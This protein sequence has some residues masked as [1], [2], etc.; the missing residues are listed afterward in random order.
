[1][2]PKEYVPDMDDEFGEG[3]DG[4]LSGAGS[5]LSINIKNKRL[6]SAVARPKTL[7]EKLLDH[8]KATKSEKGWVHA[9]DFGTNEL[10]GIWNHCFEFEP[11]AGSRNVRI[12]RIG[13]VLESVAGLAETDADSGQNDVMRRSPELAAML[14]DWVR[15]MAGKC[16][17]A[18]API[19]E[20]ESFPV[21]TGSLEYS[22]TV[23]P[24]MN[25]QGVT[26]SIAGLIES[27]ESHS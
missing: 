21:S 17:Q 1:M 7:S 3:D 16:F 26:V 12:V 9:A 11:E 19:F 14:V 6:A 15:V 27:V 18:R 25:P 20:R 22:C 5:L 4:D 10:N 8:W 2:A 13:R 23:V 24:L